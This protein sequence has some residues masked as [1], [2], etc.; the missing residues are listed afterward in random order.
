MSID[1]VDLRSFYAGALGAVTRDL[2][3]TAIANRWPDM[4]G[5]VL[6]GLG[7]ATPYLGPYREQ[8]ARCLAFMPAAQGVVN[9]PSTGLSA[10]S[11]VDADQLPLRDGSVDR[12]ILAHGLEM[13]NQPAAVLSEIWRVLSPGGRLIVIAPNRAGLWARMDGTP[14]GHGQPFSRNQL[15]SL[16][17]QALLTPVYWGEALYV[18]PVKRRLLLKSAKIWDRVGRALGL[19]FAGVHI[20]EA[21]KQVFRPVMAR[22]FAR[23]MR[24]AEPVLVPS[25][26][27]TLDSGDCAR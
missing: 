14:F 7:Y 13:T 25:R 6:L 12:V 24:D 19:P 4:N 20:I 1:I 23:V 5:S 27:L 3:V 15:T 21:T 8:T 16:M 11:L 17:R 22:R 9:W 18:P 26:R 2:L 10:S